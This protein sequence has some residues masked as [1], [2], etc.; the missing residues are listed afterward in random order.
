MKICLVLNKFGVDMNDP[1]C[2]SLGFMYVSTFLKS[3]GHEIKVLNYNLF[4]YEFKKEIKDYDSVWFTGSEE[5]LPQIKSMALQ[6]K[7]LGIT[8]YAGGLMA[9]F[10]SEKLY[11]I[12]DSIFSGEIEQ[13]LHIDK[14][15]L[16]DY[17]SFYI[18]DYHKIHPIKYM[19]ILTSRGCPFSCTFCSHVGK[20][21]ERNLNLVEEE[22]DVYLNK[23]KIELLVF[24]DNTLNIKK[25]RFLNLCAIMKTKHIAWSAAIR[26]DNFD[27]EMAVAAKSSG[28]QYFVVGV[29]SFNQERLN[30]MNKKLKVAELYNTLD[31]LHK[32]K[33][34]YHGNIILGLKTD[35]LETIKTELKNIPNGYNVFP[36]LLQHFSGVKEKSSLNPQTRKFLNAEFT[37]YAKQN[38]M[39]V[40]P[41]T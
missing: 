35:T 4:D 3:Q 34:S 16:P 36:V 13:G 19:G 29:E 31:L 26:A 38:S 18:S 2:Y 32:Y 6:C 5:F 21:R 23:Y 41:L 40:Y 22:I 27:E 24:N 33:I 11:G 30:Q 9:T 20:Y 39:N 25:T 7:E 15:G 12:V 8:T 14:I 17:E 1:C 28:C 10:K 37:N